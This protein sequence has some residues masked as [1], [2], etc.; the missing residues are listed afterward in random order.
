MTDFLGNLGIKSSFTQA[1][2]TEVLICNKNN[3]RRKQRG[4]LLFHAI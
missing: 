4:L 2:K 1:L 3:P